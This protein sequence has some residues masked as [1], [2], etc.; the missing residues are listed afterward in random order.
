MERIDDIAGKLA[1]RITRLRWLP[2]IG[3]SAGPVQIQAG[4]TL[5]RAGRRLGVEYLLHCRSSFGRSIVIALSEARSGRM[6]WSNREE[7]GDTVSPVEIDSSLTDV[8]AAGSWSG[9]TDQD[10]GER[11]RRLPDLKDR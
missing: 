1:E 3:A 8:V 5:E 10:E 6:L 11:D 2:L 4:D 9:A 7:L